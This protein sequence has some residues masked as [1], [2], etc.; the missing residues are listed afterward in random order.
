MP[1]PATQDLLYDP[2]PRPDV[3]LPPIIKPESLREDARRLV[4]QDHKEE[5]EDFLSNL[6]F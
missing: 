5:V 3:K 4:E 2:V 1:K 6:V